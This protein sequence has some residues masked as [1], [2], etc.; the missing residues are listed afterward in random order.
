MPVYKLIYFVIPPDAPAKFMIWSG[1]TEHESDNCLHKSKS[2]VFILVVSQ[3][4]N[5]EFEFSHHGTEIGVF[6]YVS[7]DQYH[8]WYLS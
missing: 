4:Q 7:L 5:Y 3:R 6:W 8:H 2:F 1:Q